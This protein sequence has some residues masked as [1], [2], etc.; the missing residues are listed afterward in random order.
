MDTLDDHIS[1]FWKYSI[2]P[3]IK[4]VIKKWPYK[5]GGLSWGDN[6][7]VY[8]YECVSKILFDK[9]GVAF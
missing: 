1:C 6:L 7:V 8:Y 2:P 9:V 3:L 4:P 5:K